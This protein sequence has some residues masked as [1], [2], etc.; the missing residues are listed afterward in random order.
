MKP[1]G[2]TVC[3][4]RGIVGGEGELVLP[5]IKPIASNTCQVRAP[6]CQVPA[7]TPLAKSPSFFKLLTTWCPFAFPRYLA[8]CMPLSP[9][10]CL[11]LFG[12]LPYLF[13]LLS[14]TLSSSLLST[15]SIL[16]L[17]HTGLKSP[18]CTQSDN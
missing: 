1:F 17:P 6:L 14:S 13:L 12:C 4:G 8:R 10:V 15:P 3:H 16:S 5:K 18:I 2:S 11:S 9:C 7:K